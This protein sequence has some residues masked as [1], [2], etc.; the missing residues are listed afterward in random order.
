MRQV[1]KKQ[2]LTF[3][4]TSNKV[5]YVPV[6]AISFLFLLTLTWSKGQIDGSLAK[7]IILH[8]DPQQCAQKQDPQSK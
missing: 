3:Q 4:Q 6:L 8:C 7:V 1:L 2:N 5:N